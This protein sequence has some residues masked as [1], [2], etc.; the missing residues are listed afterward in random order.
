MNDEVWLQLALTMY[1]DAKSIQRM[2][3]DH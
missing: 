2:F 3:H 1:G